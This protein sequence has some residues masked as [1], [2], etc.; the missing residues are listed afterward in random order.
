MN[1]YQMSNGER[2]LQSTID[3]RIKKAKATALKL[4]FEDHGYNF[5]EQCG[6]S[7]GMPLDCSHDISVKKAKENGQTE[8]CWNVG[9]ITI[10]CRK[11]HEEKDGL[12]FQFTNK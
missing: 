9:N 6:R 2:V 11:C 3:T 4:Q 12:N 10:L 1:S 7:T 8:Q 5:C